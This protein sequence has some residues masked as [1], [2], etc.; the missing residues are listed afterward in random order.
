HCR[1]PEAVDLALS[2][3]EHIPAL[4]VIFDMRGLVDAEYLAEQ[5][6]S[7][8]NAEYH[9][10]SRIQRRAARDADAL[11]CVS[12]A[13][14]DHLAGSLDARTQCITVLPCAVAIDRA[15][16]IE[17]ERRRIRQRL[18]LADRFVVAFSGGAQ[19]W[20]MHAQSARAFRLIRGIRG[21]AHF[22]VLT[23]EPN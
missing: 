19:S 16:Q 21:D 15:F 18:G 6:T 14:A 23:S 22:M 13:M 2:V 20:Q 5:G 1:G 10:L 7:S 11:F 9:R 3:R 12:D 8:N 4:K 17:I